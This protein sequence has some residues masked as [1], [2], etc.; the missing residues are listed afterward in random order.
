MIYSILLP[1][2]SAVIL[3]DIPIRILISMWTG[4]FRHGLGRLMWF[5]WNSG[6]TFYLKIFANSWWVTL[7][8]IHI[9]WKWHWIQ[10]FGLCF[11]KIQYFKIIFCY[12]VLGCSGDILTCQVFIY[13][14]TLPL[15]PVLYRLPVVIVPTNIGVTVPSV[16]WLRMQKNRI[17]SF[18]ATVS[19]TINNF[20]HL[21]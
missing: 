1:L 20:F 14:A 18:F 13:N 10:I 8:Y 12:E 7:S 15:L 16:L 21:V 19:F 3:F 2:C 4:V 17:I 5:I 9:F 6:G 11:L